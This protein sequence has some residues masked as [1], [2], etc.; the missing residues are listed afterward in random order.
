MNFEEF[1]SILKKSLEKKFKSS[2]KSVVKEITSYKIFKRVFNWILKK[3][4]RSFRN[5]FWLLQCWRE[6]CTRSSSQ[7]KETLIE[8]KKK[9]KIFEFNLRIKMRREFGTDYGKSFKK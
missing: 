1:L 4:N 3:T 2:P 8:K 6:F 9:F 5:F 7:L